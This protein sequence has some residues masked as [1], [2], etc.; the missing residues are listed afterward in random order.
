MTSSGAKTAACP[1]VL[2]PVTSHGC[3]MM[4]TLIGNYNKESLVFVYFDT[5]V[6]TI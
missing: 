3:L 2:F 4:S 1:D 5:A 6:G